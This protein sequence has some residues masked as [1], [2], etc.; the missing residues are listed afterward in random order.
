MRRIFSYLAEAPYRLLAAVTVAALAD[1]TVAHAATGSGI[2]G[3]AATF[4]TGL[5]N[6]GKT[7]LGGSVLGGLTLVGS[8]LI[9]LKTAA[10]S[11]GKEPFSPGLW[12]LGAGAGLTGLPAM[13]NIFEATATGGAGVDTITE[14]TASFQ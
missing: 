7:V 1:A 10:D 11:Q 5:S 13:A 14:G 2:G 12:R 9:K 8:G 3:V 4:N 6:M